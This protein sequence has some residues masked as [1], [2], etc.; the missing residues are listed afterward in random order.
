MHLTIPRTLALL[1]L[2][3]PGSL[4]FGEPEPKTSREKGGAA[5]AERIIDRANLFFESGTRQWAEGNT[6]FAQTQFDQAISTLMSAPADAPG[7]A[8]I[9]SR[10]QRMAEDIYRLEAY[11]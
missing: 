6:K 3:V 9:Q 8:Q 11:S 7:R 4:L 1:A 10:Y 2:S 5:G